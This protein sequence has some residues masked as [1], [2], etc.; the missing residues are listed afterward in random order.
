MSEN[1]LDLISRLALVAAE[2]RGLRSDCQSI[3]DEIQ[4]GVRPL[5]SFIFILDQEGESV[6]VVASAG[7][8]ATT[9]RRL[10]SR[11]ERTALT[12]L[13]E[14]REM[15][16]LLVNDEPTL[17]FLAGPDTIGEIICVP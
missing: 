7:L 10:E 6:R 12:R 1:P 9:F 17:D 2:P 13:F 14:L 15:T 4:R 11:I 8:D 3:V 16:R 5:Y